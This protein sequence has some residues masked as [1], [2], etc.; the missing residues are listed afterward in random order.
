MFLGEKLAGADAGFTSEEGRGGGE[1]EGCTT[2]L[3]FDADL[4]QGFLRH[5]GRCR[6]I[7]MRT[8]S[9]RCVVLENEVAS[10][11][12]SEV[13]EMDLGQKRRKCGFGSKR[14]K[15]D[16]ESPYM[17]ISSS[18]SSG[19]VWE[20]DGDDILHSDANNLQH[21]SAMHESI[22]SIL[23]IPTGTEYKN[24]WNQIRLLYNFL[25]EWNRIRVM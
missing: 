7:L 17:A 18:D 22:N 16:V 12:E 25:K 19:K 9:E 14:L 3:A 15:K 10:N 2:D 4:A 20:L 6:T 24:T 11:E 13:E 21:A 23:Q 5:G 8:S 1:E